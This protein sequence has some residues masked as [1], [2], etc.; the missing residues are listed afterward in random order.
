MFFM[1]LRWICILPLLGGG[2]G[3]IGLWCCSNSLFP[4]WFP[5]SCNI[6]YWKGSTNISTINV[7]L[8]IS[9][10]NSVSFCF[11]CFGASAVRYVYNYYTFLIDYTFYQYIMSSRMRNTWSL[12]LRRSQTS[13]GKRLGDNCSKSC[14]ERP[15]HMLLAEPHLLRCPVSLEWWLHV[16]ST[17]S[18]LA[19]CKWGALAVRSALAFI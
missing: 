17:W 16:A 4:Y 13:P 11:I 10:F 1:Y 19:G 2:L 5:S 6:H 14:K 18:A 15:C 9:P 12:P 7:E 3:L 8:S